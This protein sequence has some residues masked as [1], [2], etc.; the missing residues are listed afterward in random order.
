MSWHELCCLISMNT[1]ELDHMWGCPCCFLLCFSQLAKSAALIS[2]CQRHSRV[3]AALHGATAKDR[4]EVETV[5]AASTSCESDTGEK[6]RSCG[7]G[8]GGT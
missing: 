2:L 5:R 7:V 6:R 3:A 1:L 8:G 4:Q